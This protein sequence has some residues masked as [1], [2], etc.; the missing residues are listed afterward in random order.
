[1]RANKTIELGGP[2]AV[3]RLAKPAHG[4]L[5]LSTAIAAA[6]AAQ[7][8]SAETIAT[9][10]PE[11]VAVS[12]EAV[13]AVASSASQASDAI[14]VTGSRVSTSEYASP[15]P[16]QVVNGATLAQTGYS[17][18][19]TQL[20]EVVPAY[21]ASQTSNGSSSSK[22][23]RTATLFGLGG[24][25]VLVMVDGHRR[26]NTALLNN[27]AGSTAGA[28]VDL[29]FIPTASIG[30][31]EV[32]TDGASAQ[33]GSD[34]IAGVIN[35]ILKKNREG[36]EFSV[37]SG[38]YGSASDIG[39]QGHS[40]LTT[41]ITGE[42]GIALG[43]TG[44][45][46]DLSIEYRD[47]LSSNVDGP[48]GAPNVASQTIF[49]TP[50]KGAYTNPAETLVSRYRAFNEVVPWGQTAVGGYN[51]E[52]PLGDGIKLY[53]NGTVGWSSLLSSGTY[54]DEN[55]PAALVASASNLGPYVSP[56][57]GY[58]PF[59]TTSQNDYQGVIG[60]NGENFL[61][62]KWDA[63]VSGGYNK[64]WMNVNGI[65]AS[66]GGLTPYH[67]FYV[68]D[69]TAGEVLVDLDL[70]RSFQTSWF[71]SPLNVAA[72][73][74]Y[75]YN[76][77]GEGAGEPQSY[78]N[79]GFVFPANYPSAY[80]RGTGAG[81][82]SPFMTGITP[83]ESGDWNRSNE[84]IYVDLAQQITDKLKVDLAGRYEN[85]SDF[86]GAAS[87]KLSARYA[88]TP[89]FAVR[90]TISNGF[91]APSLAEEYTTVANQ[92]PQS[93]NGVISQV[94]SYNSIRVTS[95]A[96]IALGATPLKPETSVNYSIGFVSRPVDKLELSVDAFDIDVTN[97]IGLTGSFSGLASPQVAAALAKAG[98]ASTNT[99][100]YFTNIGNTRTYGLQ[101]K[102]KYVTDFGNWGSV[103][104]GLSY[105]L[106]RQVVTSAKNAPASLGGGALLQY[107]ALVTLQHGTP[108][109]ILKGTAEWSIDKFRLKAVETYYS[110]IYSVSTISNNAFIYNA[111]YNSYSPPAWITDLAA[112]YDVNKHMTLT[113][114]ADNVTDRRAPN[115]PPPTVSSNTSGFI[116]PAP[117]PTSYGI[118]GVFYYGRVG[119][120]W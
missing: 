68:G 111:A 79:G 108:A 60:V 24:D 9:A 66:F 90:G 41:V 115:I 16:V 18:L 77:F 2:G 44:G 30:H 93:I 23:V 3:R 34:A 14:V 102:A 75:R 80:L 118:G 22:P 61:G 46:L 31:V 84:A 95:P 28:P 50:T 19:R 5:L 1:M 109:H 71:S 10:A 104:W 73:V 119:F 113:V 8:A 11:T 33:Y 62:W 94:N 81:I 54:R 98:Y 100:A 103:E 64:A 65:N 78:L 105:V 4:A 55:N 59:L 67:K 43:Q 52:Y 88:I 39:G 40:G 7:R 21:L 89:T 107:T 37:Q 57:G 110:D 63:S 112:S 83:A 20:G 101:A 82:G 53:S 99:L 13:A 97:R 76:T 116:Y 74:E 117:V 45:F 106:N 92:G 12:A 91:R 47:V 69:L 56:T 114:G 87:G 49:A 25:E 38:Q 35:I 70:T 120:S 17:D 72:G 42:Q 27:T 29:S 36:G 6:L 15:S 26:H 32:L 96:A 48:E 85:Y 58:V 51:F 86:G